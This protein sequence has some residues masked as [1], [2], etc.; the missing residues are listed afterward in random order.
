MQVLAEC[1]FSLVLAVRA[2]SR[3]Q[4]PNYTLS[5]PGVQVLPGCK[6]SHAAAELHPTGARRASSRRMQ[7]L[8]SS[9]GATSCPL[10]T[11]KRTPCRDNIK[12]P[13]AASP[14]RE[15]LELSLQLSA[16]VKRVCFHRPGA[17]CASTALALRQVFPASTHRS[18]LSSCRGS[19]SCTG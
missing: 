8:A 6:C 17:V 4:P 14:V 9:T 11:M 2:S 3:M 15:A 12:S 5:A 19:S 18:D 16:T 10:P 13:P 1:K 7:V